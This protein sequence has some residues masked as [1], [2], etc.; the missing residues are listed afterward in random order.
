MRI[1]QHVGTGKSLLKL[2]GVARGLDFLSLIFSP[3]PSSA[4]LY[5]TTFRIE[6]RFSIWCGRNPCMTGTTITFSFFASHISTSFHS[7]IS[8]HL[9][10]N[11]ITSLLTVCCLMADKLC[12]FRF[13]LHHVAPYIQYSLSVCL[14]LSVEKDCP[15]PGRGS[16]PTGDNLGKAY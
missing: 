6:E 15:E 3:S 7:L 1:R 13:G 16:S 9:V 5:V 11:F 8:R 14:N 2:L 4:S 12:C 10:A